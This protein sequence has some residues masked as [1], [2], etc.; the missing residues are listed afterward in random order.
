MKVIF[1]LTLFLLVYNIFAQS[2]WLATTSTLISRYDDISF[3][4]P[5]TGWAAGGSD[6]FI[7]HT[8]NGGA[9]WSIQ[10]NLPGVY[11]SGGYVR[12]IEFANKN[13]GFAGGLEFSG[14]NVFF[15]TT[16]GG[17]NW[18]DISSVITGT[19]RGICGICCVNTNVTYA[20]GAFTTPAY[21]LK[22][23]D[24]G[25]TWTQINMG[26]YAGALVDVQFI[27]ANNGYVTGHSNISSEG[28]VILKTTDGGVTWT[29]VFTSNVTGEYVWKIQNLNGT[30]WYA[31]IEAAVLAATTTNN[32][33]LKSVNGGNTWISKPV[34]IGHHFQGIGFIDTLRGWIGNNELFETNDGGNSWTDISSFTTMN[35]FDRFQRVNATTAYF[36]SSKIY[37][38]A[39]PN[40]IK[41]STTKTTKIDWLKIYPNPAKEKIKFHL[42]LPHKTMFVA[43]LFNSKNEIIWEEVNQK[44]KGKHDVLIPL[45][46][47]SGIYYVY[48]MFSEG[49]ECKKVIVE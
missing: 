16:D 49:I 23:I 15:K 28:A 33:F 22:T 20:V 25:V 45:K 17:V 40:G 29:K 43:R 11:P 18:T 42:D 46:L 35:Q 21:V 38:L 12:S 13:I 14:Q 34:G 7:S 4:S 3:I 30:N 5:D 9:T 27:D 37:K 24:G 31:S 26:A 41:E 39:N 8:T 2:P 19:A 1:S 32:V 48:I 47:E 6:G 10:K 44:E 36:S